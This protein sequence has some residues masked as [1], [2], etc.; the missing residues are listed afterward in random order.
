MCLARMVHSLNKVLI[1]DIDNTGHHV[2]LEQMWGRYDDAVARLDA[3]KRRAHL[4]LPRVTKQLTV[5]ICVY[6][7]QFPDMFG[8]MRADRS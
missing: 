3:L 6:D 1:E 7:L 4:E 2:L 8:K 5:R